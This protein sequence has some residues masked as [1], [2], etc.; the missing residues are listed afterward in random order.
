VEPNVL[1]AYFRGR[2]EAGGVKQPSRQFVAITD[3]DTALHELAQREGYREIFINPSD[4]GGRYS[5]LS[6]FGMVPA[7][8]MGIDVSGLL[9]WG[10]GMALLC[11]PTNAIAQNPGVALGIAIGAAARNGRDKLTLITGPQLKPFGLW[12]EQ[13]I[14]ESTG[15]QGTGIVPIAGEPL[16][17]PS[18][19]GD[20]RLFVRL[21]L[22]GGDPEEHQ[23]DGRV[24]RL[25]AA[26]HPII[27]INL[28]EPAAIGAE[29]MRWEIAT[30]TAGA[31]LGINPFD[32]PNVQQA[33]DATKA[34]LGQYVA[35][36]KLPGPIPQIPPESR[37]G[38]SLTFDGNSWGTIGASSKNAVT[39]MGEFLRLVQK[40][41]YAGILAYLPFDAPIGE[42]LARLRTAIRDRSR[43]ATMFGYGPR[44][45]HST[46][47]LHKG[48][49][50][51]GVFVLITADPLEDLEI[52]GEKYSFGV[53]EL[54]QALGDFASLEATG[55]PA[56]RIHLRAPDLRA[57]DSACELL[58]S[59]L[60]K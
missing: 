50:N 18:V 29:F 57:V 44:Y 43:V 14:A 37:D 59:A 15:K 47:Q 19:Y 55:R 58:E 22:H 25:R 26:G 28:K 52:P 11:A 53:L 54:A 1:S 36:G 46:G 24:E 60:P 21:R 2:L 35:A 56:V 13:L 20:D 16:G 41:D 38:F 34:L 12:I 4:I 3:Q 45:L 10:R 30:A 48:G 42:R 49:P 6:F 40:G 5:A 32:E 39:A 8:L 9:A 33:K 17:P 51:T 27:T 7:A 23:R 31:I